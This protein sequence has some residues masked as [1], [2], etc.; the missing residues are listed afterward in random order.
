MKRLLICLV[1][2]ASTA[3]AGFLGSFSGYRTQI[4]NKLNIAVAA[5]SPLSDS[6]LNDF[7]RE[8][9]VTNVPLM[10]GI[11]VKVID[12]LVKR[13]NAYTLDSTLLY[14]KSVVWNK[15]DSV[16]SLLYLPQE[17]WYSKEVKTTSGKKEY[18]RI[19]SYYDY[20]DTY[21]YLYP[22]PSVVENDTLEIRGVRRMGSISTLDSL[23]LIPEVYQTPILLY[24][25]YLAAQAISNPMTP[26]L[27]VEYEKSLANI[28]AIMNRVVINEN[29]GQ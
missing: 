16:K 25:T 22:S 27:K 8:A 18:D 7:V 2:L 3:S 12:T 11:K 1:L 4:K 29:T 13:Q 23:V 10:Q 21:L 9:V 15:Y 5:T 28:N 26:L 6:V 14:V 20:D 19:P 17:L 24:A